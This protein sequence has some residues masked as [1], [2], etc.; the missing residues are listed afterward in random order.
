MFFIVSVHLNVRMNNYIIDIKTNECIFG[1]KVNKTT[2]EFKL[3]LVDSAK[4]MY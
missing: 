2:F 4:N 1:D 3:N